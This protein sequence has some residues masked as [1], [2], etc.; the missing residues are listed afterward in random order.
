MKMLN[1]YIVFDVINALGYIFFR[2]MFS[3]TRLSII[4]SKLHYTTIG[5]YIHSF[6]NHA[7]ASIALVFSSKL[8]DIFT[9]GRQGAW[10]AHPKSQRRQVLQVLPKH[11][12]CTCL[13]RVMVYYLVRQ[14]ERFLNS[15]HAKITPFS[16]FIT[17]HCISL[18]TVSFDY[19]YLT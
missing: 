4:E 5:G 12:V 18:L 17:L 14:G 10:S 19:M 15:A 1:G 3:T 8:Q 2:V 9:R 13:D 7:K 6:F 11:P 16:H